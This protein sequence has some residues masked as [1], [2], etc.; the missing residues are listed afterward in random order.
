MSIKNLNKYFYNNTNSKILL[1]LLTSRSILLILIWSNN[2]YHGKCIWTFKS[3]YNI[4]YFKIVK[5]FA[6]FWTSYEIIFSSNFKFE[7]KLR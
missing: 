3:T 1:R 5:F 4:L 2:Q 6:V 7:I